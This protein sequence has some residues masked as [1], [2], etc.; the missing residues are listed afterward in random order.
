MKKNCKILTAE[1]AAKEMSSIKVEDAVFTNDGTLLARYEYTGINE[2]ERRPIFSASEIAE[3]VNMP[4]WE[5]VTVDNDYAL[6]LYE[7]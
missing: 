7:N 6:L 5:V 3:K 1:Q 2:F 4:L